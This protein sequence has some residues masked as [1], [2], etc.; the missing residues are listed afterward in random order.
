MKRL[1]KKD[2]N[3]AINGEPIVCSNTEVD[4]YIERPILRIWEYEC[5]TEKIWYTSQ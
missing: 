5:P 1:K 3:S 2:W 4:K